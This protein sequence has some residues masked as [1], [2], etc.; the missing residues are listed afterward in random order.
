[1]AGG[2]DNVELSGNSGLCCAM[3]GDIVPLIREQGARLGG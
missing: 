2:E 3:T 1:M